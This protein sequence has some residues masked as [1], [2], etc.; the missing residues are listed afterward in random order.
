MLN[1]NMKIYKI[2]IFFNNAFKN[3]VSKKQLRLK[4]WLNVNGKL[5]LN[6]PNGLKNSLM[7]IMMDMNIILMK[8]NMGLNLWWVC[9]RKRH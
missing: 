3:V 7:I 8:E 5:I 4:N 6:L 1:L 2:L 9:Q